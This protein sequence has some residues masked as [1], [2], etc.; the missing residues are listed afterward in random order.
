M[1][2][3][4]AVKKLLGLIHPEHEGTTILLNASN[5]LST[6][7]PYCPKRLES[8]T[9]NTSSILRYKCTLVNGCDVSFILEKAKNKTRAF[10]QLK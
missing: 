8:Y 3:Q 10:Q 9:L 2:T 4:Q 5:Y 7:M 6:D 1:F